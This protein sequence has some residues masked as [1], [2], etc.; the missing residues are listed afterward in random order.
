MCNH[1]LYT[2]INE[3]CILGND[4]NANDISEQLNG[5]FGVNVNLYKYRII[6]GSFNN[7]DVVLIT[8]TI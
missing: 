4:I 7:S 1:S 5:K 2:C 3:A 8:G 6:F